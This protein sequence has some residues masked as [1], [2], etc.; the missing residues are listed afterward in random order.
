VKKI[1]KAKALE[2]GKKIG[3]NFNDIDIEQFRMGVPVEL[4]HRNVTHGNL[5]TTGRI[6]LAHLEEIPDYYTRLD[7]MEE[8]YKRSK[9]HGK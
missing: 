4:E 8:G 1:S 9:K 6:A 5:I 3:I 7:K 2:L